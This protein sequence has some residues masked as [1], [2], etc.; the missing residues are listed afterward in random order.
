[1]GEKRVTARQ[2]PIEDSINVKKMLTVIRTSGGI[3][4]HD[5]CISAGEGISYI[6]APATV[7]GIF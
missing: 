1:M 3:R 5:P 4:K 6:G 7:F 2:L